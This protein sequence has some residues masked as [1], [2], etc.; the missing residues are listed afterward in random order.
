MVCIAQSIR[1]N[2]CQVD[3]YRG[4]QPVEDV[5]QPLGARLSGDA[6]LS[7][8]LTK[9]DQH[10]VQHIGQAQRLARRGTDRDDGRFTSCRVEIDGA[11]RISLID[12]SGAVCASTEQHRAGEAERRPARA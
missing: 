12:L 11:R 9:A 8:S 5:V 1:V 7:K 6:P 10:R 2:G 3:L 4:I